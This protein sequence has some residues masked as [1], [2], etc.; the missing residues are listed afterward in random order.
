MHY[1]YLGDLALIMCHM[2]F[3]SHLCLGSREHILAIIIF[4][5]LH[6]IICTSIIY[7]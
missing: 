6:S 7:Q 5:S 2:V 3:T 4:I 1:T